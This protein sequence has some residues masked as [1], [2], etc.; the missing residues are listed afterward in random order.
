M[1]ELSINANFIAYCLIM[2]QMR[3]FILTKKEEKSQADAKKLW[4]VENPDREHR[5]DRQKQREDDKEI[6][7]FELEVLR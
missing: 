7:L 5:F 4:L 1:T 2:R 6:H 3:M